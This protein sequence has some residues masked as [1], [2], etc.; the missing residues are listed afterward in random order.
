M[1]HSDFLYVVTFDN[2]HTY[3]KTFTSNEKP[4][5]VYQDHMD[6]YNNIKY[7]DNTHKPNYN[8][9]VYYFVNP[10]DELMKSILSQLKKYNNTELNGFYHYTNN[11]ELLSE[12]L[13]RC[14]NIQQL[15]QEMGVKQHNDKYYSSENNLKLYNPNEPVDELKEVNLDLLERQKKRCDDSINESPNENEIAFGLPLSFDVSLLRNNED[16]ITIDIKKKFENELMPLQNNEDV[17]DDTYLVLDKTT[18]EKKEPEPLLPTPIPEKETSDHVKDY[19]G[20]PLIDPNLYNKLQKCT[21]N[22]AEAYKKMMND[23]E[24]IDNKLFEQ[25]DKPNDEDIPGMPENLL[26]CPNRKRQFLKDNQCQV[27]S[28]N[29]SCTDIEHNVALIQNLLIS[30]V[31]YGLLVTKDVI[32]IKQSV[33]Y[34]PEIKIIQDFITPDDD[35]YYSCVAIKLNKTFKK[36]N[37]DLKKVAN[38]MNEILSSVN[39]FLEYGEY[40]QYLL[41]ELY[42]KQTTTLDKILLA[43][44]DFSQGYERTSGSRCFVNGKEEEPKYMLLDDFMEEFYQHLIQQNFDITKEELKNYETSISQY[45]VFHRCFEM[46]MDN[47]FQKTIY[48]KKSNKSIISSRFNFAPNP[49]LSTMAMFGTNTRTMSTN[50][51]LREEVLPIVDYEKNLSNAWNQS[52]LTAAKPKN[53]LTAEDLLPADTNDSWFKLNPIKQRSLE[54]EPLL[55]SSNPIKTIGCLS[56]GQRREIK[57]F[58]VPKIPVSPWQQTTI[59][60]ELERI[61]LE[62]TKTSPPWFLSVPVSEK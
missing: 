20:V 62:P 8:I 52:S 39:I 22:S 28:T 18:P 41:T 56:G 47:D 34:F 50:K 11:I 59:E 26:Y 38:K 23:R 32:S 5:K 9:N 13:N 58:Q 15:L 21:F 7:I 1:L 14:K 36:E 24:L 43:I 53:I 61:P 10:N 44:K 25:L 31:S 4:A 35:E 45:L 46:G 60:P 29:L 27:Y 54:G 2:P 3:I 17:I 51:Q 6:I 57:D 30:T 37:N 33:N 49:V 42:D 55:H 19:L 16:N 40:D 12:L 48:I